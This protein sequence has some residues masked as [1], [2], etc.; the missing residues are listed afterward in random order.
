MPTSFCDMFSAPTGMD[1]QTGGGGGGFS[2]NNSSPQNENRR[3]SY[4]EQTLQPV[5][6]RMVLTAPSSDGT[7]SLADGRQLYH[8]QIVGA[9]KTISDNSTNIL[10]EIEDGT[11]L[12]EVKKWLDTSMP[13]PISNSDSKQL[14]E[15]MYVK[16]VGQIKDYDGKKM[17]VADSIR[18]LTTGNELTHHCLR[19]VFEAEQALRASQYVAAAPMAMMGGVGGGGMHSAG[20]GFGATNAGGAPLVSNTMGSGDSVQEAVSDFFRVQGERSDL[21]AAVSECVGSFAGK[22][23]EQQIRNAV[24]ILSSEGNIYST[25]D[26]EHFKHSGI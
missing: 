8:V 15:H 24:F 19:V 17:I 5:T 2:T 1:Y 13:D 22:F 14:T 18:P 12:I 11:G 4:D 25:I 7:V 23:T 26:D 20:V 10:Y 3:R 21:G 9:I 16:V 6:V